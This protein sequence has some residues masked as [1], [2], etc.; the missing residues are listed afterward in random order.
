MQENG[1]VPWNDTMLKKLERKASVKTLLWLPGS[2]RHVSEGPDSYKP[3]THITRTLHLEDALQVCAQRRMPPKNIISFSSIDSRALPPGHPCAD[4]K[5]LWFSAGISDQ[6]EAEDRHDWYGNVEFAVKA[7][8]LLQRWKYSFLVEMMTTPT[9]TSSRILLTNTDFSG[10]L[11]PY[12]PYCAGGPWHV[13]AE[14]QSALVK[15][16]RYRFM[17]FNRHPHILEFLLDVNAR[18]EKKMLKLCQLSFKNHEEAQDL[19]VRHVCNRYQ[20]AKTNCPTPFPRNVTAKVFVERLCQ[21]K[22][23]PHNVPKLSSLSQELYNEAVQQ[24]VLSPAVPCVTL[25]PPA[26][27]CATLTPNVIFTNFSAQSF[28]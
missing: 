8:V 19:T 18:D 3:F 4:L 6:D 17:G 12:D 13:S 21:M 24:P 9:H 5:V 1:I 26:V 14:G 25:M 11:R 20:R 2:G 7:S 23:P 28:E 10:V 16:S 27:P 22:V 15:C